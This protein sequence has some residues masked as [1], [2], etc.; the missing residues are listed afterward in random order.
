MGWVIFVVGLVLLLGIHSER[1]VSP[2]FRRGFIAQR[3]EKAWKILYSVV[4]IVGFVLLVWGYG[5]ARQRAPVLYVSNFNLVY[6]TAALMLIALIVLASYKL[7]A[8]RIKAT[9]KHP[10]LVAVKIWAL[11]HLLVNGDLA[12]IVLF[13]S[14]L[15]WAVADRIS[16][17]K[18]WRAGIT[19]NPV[20]VSYKYDAI[21][22]VIGVV[23]YGLFTWK[24]HLWLIGVQPPV[25]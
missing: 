16:E 7:P 19:Q 22:V 21:A 4:A 1:I 11:A 8:G 25:G 13:V 14:F 9:L 5:I 20:F 2:D 15:A 17:K 18:R 10:M 3:G 24:L 6:V 12:S 23:L